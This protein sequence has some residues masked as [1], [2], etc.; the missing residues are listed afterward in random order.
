[1]QVNHVD[2]N[3]REHKFHMTPLMIAS[4]QG[5]RDIVIYLI[6]YGANVNLRDTKGYGI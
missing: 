2:V 3:C 5:S 6:Y 4:L 1:M